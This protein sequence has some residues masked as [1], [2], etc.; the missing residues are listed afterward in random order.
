MV[1][2]ETLL[3]PREGFGFPETTSRG[4]SKLKENKIYC[5]PR[6][7]TL[8][9]FLYNDREKWKKKQKL[10]HTDLDSF[11]RF[12]AGFS[13]AQ[14]STRN[15]SVVTAFLIAFLYFSC[16]SLNKIQRSIVERLE[17]RSFLTSGFICVFVS[18]KHLSATWLCAIYHWNSC[19]TL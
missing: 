1:P 17:K 15:T 16:I 9:I 6:D 3:F 2:R 14:T 13:S 7:K 4:T 10:V 12:F 11:S 8:N 18:N 5:F 19:D